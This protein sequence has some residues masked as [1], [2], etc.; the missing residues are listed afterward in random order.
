MLSLSSLY[1]ISTCSPGSGSAAEGQNGSTHHC[2]LLL[3]TYVHPTHVRVG[4]R[5]TKFYKV[6]RGSTLAQTLHDTWVAVSAPGQSQVR[7]STTRGDR[8]RLGGYPRLLVGLDQDQ[9]LPRLHQA[10]EACRNVARWTPDDEK[11][12]RISEGASDCDPRALRCSRSPNSHH[13]HP[14]LSP[15]SAGTPASPSNTQRLTQR[16]SP[17]CGR[18]DVRRFSRSVSCRDRRLRPILRV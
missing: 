2:G 1:V 7:R 11:W 8:H 4:Q 9:T 17:F 16:R 6:I 15:R 3:A 13:G 5:A 14:D 12:D 18:P 10:S